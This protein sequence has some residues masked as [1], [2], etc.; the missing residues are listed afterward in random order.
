MAA[1][2]EATTQQVVTELERLGLVA[3][4]LPAR[5]EKGQQVDCINVWVNPGS[6]YPVASV[7]APFRGDGWS[8]GDK[9]QWGAPAEA[10]AATVAERVS[11]TV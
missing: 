5:P 3:E 10:D 6:R 7:Y 9:F 2:Q 1:A 4:V 8:W 11:R